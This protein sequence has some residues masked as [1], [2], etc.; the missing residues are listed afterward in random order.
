MLTVRR[1]YS[2]LRGLFTVL[3]NIL[4]FQ[5]PIAAAAAMADHMPTTLA[6]FGYT[7]NDSK[8]WRAFC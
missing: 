4:P 2:R 6:G 8:L 7:F 1:H 3:A 5:S